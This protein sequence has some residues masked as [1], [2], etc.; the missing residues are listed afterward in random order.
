MKLGLAM[1]TVRNSFKKDPL[2]T[3]D[4]IAKA[5]YKNI[6]LV[7]HEANVSIHGGCGLDA[8]EI[9]AKCDDLGIN[10]FGYQILP[11]YSKN[12]LDTFFDDL[13][14]IQR[15]IDYAAGMGCTMV[16]IGI[17]FF[18]TMDYLIKR[19]QVYNKIGEMCKASG[20]T[21]VYH[22]H[23][24]EYQL[25]DGQT[26]MDL[27]IQNTDPNLVSL[28]VDAYWVIRGLYDPVK[29]IRKYAKLT[30]IVAIHQ[31]DFPL[32]KVNELSA[33]N[34]IDQNVP[35]NWEVFHDAI[36]PEHFIELG[37]GICK[38]QDLIDTCNELN[39]PYLFLEQDYSTYPELES[40][41]ISMDNMKSRMR[42]L[43]FDS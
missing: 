1:F 22:N 41:Q 5:G 30:N 3:L 20:M 29:E 21:F 28:E 15:L 16:S 11:A 8:K 27:I 36:K 35:L 43:E 23:Y 40:I 13:D 7:N 12:V 42:G 31:K 2:G 9:K 10:I 19:C 26:M 4:A 25:L 18:P 32:A 6:E 14:Q 33:W 37:E 39:I 17:D 34:I 38:I 24:S